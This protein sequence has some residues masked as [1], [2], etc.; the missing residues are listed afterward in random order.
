MKHTAQIVYELSWTEAEEILQTLLDN[1]TLSLHPSTRDQ[2][3]LEAKSSEQELDA[4][5]IDERMT[6]YFG[7]K[8][9][10]WATVDGVLVTTNSPLYTLT[11][12]WD[13][14]SGAGGEVLAASAD[15]SVLSDLLLA[16]AAA[17]QTAHASTEWER[18]LTEIPGS[19]DETP[20]YASFGW[21][22]GYC[23]N[24]HRWIISET[25]L[26]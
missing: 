11:H 17:F 4:G 16:Q 7:T 8:C 13:D 15:K 23:E 19:D 9:I 18:D 10:C 20:L 22:Q 25:D 6:Q 26:I 2:R 21:K 24:V 14:D 3:L 12:T 5:E 1:K